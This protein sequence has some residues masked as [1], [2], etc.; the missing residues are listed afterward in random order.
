MDFVTSKKFSFVSDAL[1]PDAFGV[2]HFKGSEAI[3]RPYEFEVM[4]V[5]K[6]LEIDLPRVIQNPARL[7]IHRPDKED[8]VYRGILADFEQLH[9]VGEYG[10]YR[11][12]LVPKLWWLS[13][14]RHNQVI[15]NKSLPDFI[16][17]VL[18]DGGLTALDFE[19]RL[20]KKYSPV[21]Y[22][23]QYGESH[24]NFVSRWLE[25]EG[26]YYFFE[27]TP[28]GEKVVFT[29]T[30]AAHMD[31]PQGKTLDYSPPSGLDALHMAETVKTFSCRQRMVPNRVFLKDYNY[32]KPS[33]DVTGN[34]QVDEN[35]RGHVYYYNEH[36][37][38]GEDGERL[39]KIRSESILCRREEFRGEGSV[40]YMLP[41]FTFDLQKHF[42]KDFNRKYLATEVD[43]EGNQTGYLISGIREGLSD[44][45]A[46]IYYRNFFTAI[47][48]DVQFRPEAKAEKPRVAGTIVARVDAAG[49]G[50][51]AELDEHGRY[52]IV[53]PFDLSGRKDGKASAWVRM[54]Q[55]YAGSDHGMHFPLHKNTEVLLTFI[56]GDPDRPIIA[57]AVPNPETPSPVRSGNQTMSAI[58][59]GGGNKIHI[60]DQEGNERIL[61][62]A[63]NKGS[64]IRIGAP[65]DPETGESTEDSWGIHLFTRKALDI[66][67]ETKN[68][69]ILGENAELVVG[70]SVSTVFGATMDAKWLG[71]WEIK[72]PEELEFSNT[73]SAVHAEEAKFRSLATTVNI[74]DENHVMNVRMALTDLDTRLANTDTL[75]INQQT[76]LARAAVILRGEIVEARNSAV[77]VANQNVEAVNNR[78]NTFATEINSA[79]TSLTNSM[80]RIDDIGNNVQN[81]AML[82]QNHGTRVSN[83]SLA[84]E[85]APLIMQN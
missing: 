12:Y 40:P 66:K 8:V 26:I 58:T 31:F 1:S 61:L 77:Q 27:Q 34:A 59:T 72:W 81:L 57:S 16:G 56:D 74:G 65:N 23:C 54:A 82:V 38:T 83:A 75:L 17:D 15:L 69:I 13:L 80:N 44:R 51:Y 55:P 46:Q 48:A 42:R 45:E 18:K 50:K 68:E 21:D 5:S 41:G 14:T 43:H 10:F 70:A 84:L 20:Q 37:Q 7:V 60:E 4:L 29:D 67:A 71:L 33:L 64:F 35:G 73:K 78:L 28:D 76:S 32:M 36:F 2:V 22:V 6:D 39:A 11:A 9:A 63:P 25:R 24:L 52:K 79:G 3:S 49:S 47:R 53:L 85:Q 30:A 19:F 62:H